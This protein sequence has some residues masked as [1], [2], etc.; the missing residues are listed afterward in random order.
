MK[1]DKHLRPTP[2]A[3]H[4]DIPARRFW[5]NIDRDAF[6]LALSGNDKYATFVQALHDPNYSRCSFPA[7]LRKFNISLHEAQSLYTDYHRQLM[8]LRIATG[9]P[10]VAADV[11]EDAKSKMETC[12]RCD[13]ERVVESTRGNR[14]IRKACPD[15]KGTGEVRVIGDRHARDLVFE[16]MKLTKQPGPLVAIN[17]SIGTAG[18]LDSKFEDMMKLT[19]AIVSAPATRTAIEDSN[20]PMVPT[21]D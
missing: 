2:D 21:L 5:N 12:P 3:A 15:C 19:Q 17:Q 18:A 9:A 14:K 8:L 1:R 20:R 10:Q 16:T 13:G 7:L 11:V 6:E 4:R